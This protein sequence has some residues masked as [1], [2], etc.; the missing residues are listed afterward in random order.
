[1]AQH[2]E[3]RQIHLLSDSA[4]AL[5]GIPP[6][7]TKAKNKTT[8]VG[9]LFTAVLFLTAKGWKLLSIRHNRQAE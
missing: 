4:S 6:K 1:M 2:P 8:P 5:R 9:E 7:G 3:E